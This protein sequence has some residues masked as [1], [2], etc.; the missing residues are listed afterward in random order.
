MSFTSV[1]ALLDAAQREQKPLAAVILEADCRENGYAAEYS[2]RRMADTWAAM[3]DSSRQ[4]RASDRSRSGLSGGDGERLRQAAVDGR[5]LGGTY[6]LRVTEEAL[7][8]AECNACMRRIVAAPTAGSCGVLP[9]VLI[10]LAEERALPESMVAEALYIAAAFGEVTASRASVSGAQGGCQA[11]IGTA[12]AMAAAA[13]VHLQGG[14]AQQCAH[15]FALALSNLL[16]LVCDPVAGLVELPCVRRNVIGAVN[17]I[18]AADMALAGIIS[19][20]PA[21]EVIDA[22]GEIGSSLPAALRETGLGGLA[23]TPTAQRLTE[24]IR[25]ES[26]AEE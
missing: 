7:R 23:A 8:V 17:A 4:Y 5:L 3:L 13:L 14:S 22:M 10:P 19:P 15:A 20:I 12:S 16:G 6:F 24:E 25:R 11:E 1:A 9:A 18:S 2:R 26:A 21:D